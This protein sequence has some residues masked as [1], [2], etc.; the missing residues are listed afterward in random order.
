MA[1]PSF[2]APFVLD[3]PPVPTRREGNIDI[4]APGEHEAASPAVLFVH[5]GPLPV[6]LRPTPREWPLFVCYAR[7]AASYGMIGVTLDHRLHEP[8]AYSIAQDDVAEALDLVRAL[9]EVDPDRVAL[10]FFSGGAPL[11]ARWI[12]RPPDWLRCLALSYPV[13]A[14]APAWGL[15]P[16]MRP[17]EAL[18]QACDL[19]ILLT[20][21]GNEQPQVADTVTA[22]MNAAVDHRVA[23]DVIDVPDGQHSFDILDHTPQSRDAVTAAMTQTISH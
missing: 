13:L 15:G 22:F 19:P 20:R 18:A 10:W 16:Q 8:T 6:D 17:I 5:G 12:A 2:L 3:P 14:T 9:P 11:S 21:V 23:V 7:L 4:Y 1:L